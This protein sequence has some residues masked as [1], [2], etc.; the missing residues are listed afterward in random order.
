MPQGLCLHLASKCMHNVTQ[1]AWEAAWQK[2]QPLKTVL[3]QDWCG[4]F[5][6]PGFHIA[7]WTSSSM[8]AYFFQKLWFYVGPMGGC[9]GTPCGRG[10]YGWGSHHKMLLTEKMLS[11]M[12]NPCELREEKVT[13]LLPLSPDKW[14]LN[15]E[16][17]FHQ[18]GAML[19]EDTM[20]LTSPPSTCTQP[21]STGLTHISH[22]SKGQSIPHVYI[23]QMWN[24]LQFLPYITDSIT[25][26]WSCSDQK[27]GKQD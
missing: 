6:T 7:P 14:S 17:A 3:S 1:G 25:V 10:S 19:G 11:S 21:F 18:W 22:H 8:V 12:A 9:P 2:T 26:T 5:K 24:G 4:H 27:R 20:E 15:L 16:R 13:A 23:V